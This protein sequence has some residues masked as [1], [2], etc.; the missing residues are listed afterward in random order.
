MD[1]IFVTR[2]YEDIDDAD[3]LDEAINELSG[4]A[5]RLKKLGF[6]ID[7]LNRYLEIVNYASRFEID[8]MDS[9][10]ENSQIK[11][12]DLIILAIRNICNI[13]FELIASPSENDHLLFA[14]Y[15]PRIDDILEDEGFGEVLLKLNSED[16][17]NVEMLRVE[18]LIDIGE[19][20]KAINLFKRIAKHSKVGPEYIIKR[21]KS[22]GGKLTG[23]DESL[24]LKNPTKERERF[25][26]FGF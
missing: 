26:K 19:F 12:Y 11:D 7:A 2:N 16:Q 24:N 21:I 4:E 14:H 20:A 17:Y 23:Y 9:D 3:G 10:E 15:L 22:K 5:F 18:I 1:C 25:E 6:P 13:A 8:F